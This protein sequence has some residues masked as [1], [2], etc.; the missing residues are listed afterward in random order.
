ME[1]LAQMLLAPRVLDEDDLARVD[2]L[3]LEAPR[4]PPGGRALDE[5]DLEVLK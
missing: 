3:G 4:H 2:L 1:G 5:R